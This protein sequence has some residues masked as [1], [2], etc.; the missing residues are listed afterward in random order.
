MRLSIVDRQFL[1]EVAQK[2]APDL[3]PAQHEKMIDAAV[4]TMRHLARVL[5]N[6]PRRKRA[7]GA[8]VS[9]EYHLG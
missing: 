5:D 1:L 3:P 7:A 6:A 8:A 4:R 2:I 9:S